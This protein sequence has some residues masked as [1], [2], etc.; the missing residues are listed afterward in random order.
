[1]HKVLHM[2]LIIRLQ[3]IHGKI[4]KLIFYL[5]PMNIFKWRNDAQNN[6]TQQKLG[7]KNLAE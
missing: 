3:E 2:V 7:W 1:M 5:L 4:V 6:D